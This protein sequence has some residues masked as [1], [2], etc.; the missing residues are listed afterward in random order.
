[1]AL[2]VCATAAQAQ[3]TTSSIRG[4]ISA[5]GAPVS[6]ARVTV[7]HVPSGTVTTATTDADGAFL[8]SGLRVGGPFTVTVEAS[9]YATAT[10]TDIQLTAGQPLKLP[11]E[12]SGDE[13]VVTASQRK[14]TELSSGPISAFNRGAIEGVASIARDARD[15]ARRDPFVTLDPTNNRTIQI[16]GQNGRLNKFSVDGVRFSDMLGLNSGGLPTARGPVPFDAI[17]QFSVKIAPYDISEADFQGGAVNVVLRSGGNRFTGSAF[18][19]YTSD[20]LTGDKSRDATVNLDFTSRTFGGFLS[21]PIIKDK[22]FFAVAYERLKEGQPA[23][24]G[25]AGFPNVVPNL[26]DAQIAQVGTIAQSIYR[27]DTLGV[28]RTVDER[29]EKYTAKLD[30][31]ITDGQRA[32]F[33]YIHNAGNINV[34]TNSAV[35][36]ASPSLGLASDVYTRPEKVDS[37]VFQLNSDWSDSFHSEFRANYRK[38]SQLP[39]P[40][41]DINFGQF[42]VCLDPTSAVQQNGAANTNPVACSQGSAAA[43]GAARLF[44]GPDQFRHYSSLGTK[45]YGADLTLRWQWRSHTVK[46][47]ATWSHFDVAN[48]FVANGRGT[49]YFDSLADFQ[50]RRASS[51][52]LQGSIDGDLDKLNAYYGYSAFGFGMQDSWEVSDRLNLTFGDRVDL[53]AM[54]DRPPLNSFFVS[55]YGFRNNATFNGKMVH[56]PR[57]GA[58]WKATDELTLR[59]GV[60]VF[61]GGSP[62]ILMSNSFTAAGVFNNTITVQRSGV[63][64]TGCNL[65]PAICA[66]ALDNVTGTSFSQTV[67]DYLRTNT[68]SLASS[69]VNAQALNYKLASSMK[70]SFSADYKADLGGLGHNWNFGGDLYYSKVIN[71]PDYIDLRAQAVGTTPDGRPRYSTATGANNDLFLF[72]SK[73]GHSFIA[74]ARIDAR[75]GS[76]LG[77]GVSYT[78]QDIEDVNPINATT[79]VASYGQ[80]AMVDPNHGQLGTSIYQTRRAL[81]FNF[82]FDRALFGDYKTRFSL[83]GELRSG[84]PYSLTMNDPTLVNGRSSVFGTVGAANRYLLYVPNVASITADP[85][86]TYDSAATFSAFQAFVQGNDLK[87]GAIISKNTRRAPD[88]F[89]VDLHVDQELPVPLVR[90]AR[91]K[92]FA[93][94]ENVLNLI[95]KDWGSLRQV[96]FPYLANVVNVACVANGANAC[97]QYRYSSFQNPTIVNQTRFSL[98]GIRVG[99]KFEF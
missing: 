40:L 19:T 80:T 54:S 7:T 24:F 84:Q 41:G 72:N 91:I 75:W 65:A 77:A 81:K 45:N 89:K 57:F 44:F 4:Q 56:Q 32:S 94:V 70:S 34:Q 14:A 86:V 9:G 2:A 68:A 71:A 6:G 73:K 51:L 27:Y 20:K 10:T 43:P 53:Y 59:G 26:T 93:D 11:I 96:I 58:T 23:S 55:R 3:E 30:W 39:M 31:N 15:I 66:A 63:G 5:A 67:L 88:F 76:G 36:P 25:T 92:L 79:S 85:L 78:F 50:N 29:D 62:D 21:G 13:I 69:S 52:V 64:G 37:G 48:V 74:V 49:Y 22:L 17:E 33:T 35:T 60:G 83:F 42:Q 28:L 12:L 61:G 87:Q 16:A 38:Y 8:S 1:M 82:N 95:N 46:M 99:A 97:A 47:V 98:W 90:G 18:Y